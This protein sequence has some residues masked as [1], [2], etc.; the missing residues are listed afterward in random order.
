MSSTVAMGAESRWR[1]T[2]A[3]HHPGAQ[4][5]KGIDSLAV[6]TLDLPELLTY[7]SMKMRPTASIFSFEK[8]EFLRV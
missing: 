2:P 8:S 3:I 4:L 1:S 5:E 6:P 7:L